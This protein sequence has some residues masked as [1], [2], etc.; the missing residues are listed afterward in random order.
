MKVLR[1]TVNLLF[2]TDLKSLKP[3]SGSYH[4][5]GISMHNINDINEIKLHENV[6][7]FLKYKN[8]QVK[9]MMWKFKYFLDNDATQTCTYILYD[10]LIADAS[11]RI[12]RLPFRI[13]HIVLHYPSSTYFKEKKE[14]DQMKELTLALDSLQ[15]SITPF[16]TCCT[17]AVLPNQNTLQDLDSQHKGTRQQRFKWSKQ[18]FILSESFERYMEAY[19]N[20]NTTSRDGLFFGNQKP[21]STTISMFKKRCAHTHIYCID[22]IVT[23]GASMHAVSKLLESKFKVQVIKFCIC[24]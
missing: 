15:N 5:Y 4:Q 2:P 7:Y 23:T 13:P 14:F 11:D 21:H 16:F 12:S 8:Q 9:K 10:Q 19:M 20:S 1:D 18:R 22:D 24:H 6:F 3:S 17:H